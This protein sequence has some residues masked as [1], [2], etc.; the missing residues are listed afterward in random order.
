M[1]LV[2]LSLKQLD[3]LQTLIEDADYGTEVPDKESA[4]IQ[5]LLER[6]RQNAEGSVL[7]RTSPVLTP[8]SAA[9]FVEQPCGCRKLAG[10]EREPSDAGEER[11]RR[12]LCFDARS[13]HA[14]KPG[15]VPCYCACHDHLLT[16][17]LVPRDVRD[18]LMAYLT[19][20]SG[21]PPEQT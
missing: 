2:E 11:A 17:V 5:A 19:A 18:A 15:D 9:A 6:T 4:P 3:V 10:E 8:G 16:A 14:T 12:T 7:R 13:I 1:P 20:I 21:E